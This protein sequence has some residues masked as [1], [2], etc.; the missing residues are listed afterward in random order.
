MEDIDKRRIGRQLSSSSD[1]RHERVC[2]L[3]TGEGSRVAV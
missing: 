1:G 3:V 2:A